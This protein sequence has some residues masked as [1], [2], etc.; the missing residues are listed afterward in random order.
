MD[1]FQC[2]LSENFFYH[3]NFQIE[4]MVL[5]PVGYNYVHEIDFVLYSFIVLLDY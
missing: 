5:L 4:I 2:D 3:K 1:T